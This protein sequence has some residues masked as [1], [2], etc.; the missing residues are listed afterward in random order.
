MDEAKYLEGN[1]EDGDD[2]VDE[3]DDFALVADADDGDDDDSWGGTRKVSKERL[4]HL[5]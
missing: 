2:E 1:Y 4:Q 5:E 3:D